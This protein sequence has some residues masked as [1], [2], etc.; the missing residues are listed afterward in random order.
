[1]RPYLD[2]NSALG[3]AILCGIVGALSG[4]WVN[5]AFADSY[6]FPQAN[7]G[8]PYSGFIGQTVQLDGT[9]SYDVNPGA[10]LSYGW[11]FN[12]DG[13]FT[14]STLSRP[15]F[16]ANT[17]GPFSIGLQVTDNLSGLSSIAYATAEIAAMGLVAK[18]V[19]VK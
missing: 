13:I 12:H 8:G 1:M 17:T 3:Q 19:I 6:F 11:D 5:S 14:D 9:G 16:T 18:L 7:A 10:I 2:S 15:I 4:I